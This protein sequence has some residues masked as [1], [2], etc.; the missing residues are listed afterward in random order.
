MSAIKV[1][2]IL[3]ARL[4]DCYIAAERNRSM[5]TTLL[6]RN[7]EQA[8]PRNEAS[9]DFYADADDDAI[10]HNEHNSFKR[11]QVQHATH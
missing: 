6:E 11:R 1:K 8:A 3:I 4:R 10:E 7:S 5:P 9:Y 2:T